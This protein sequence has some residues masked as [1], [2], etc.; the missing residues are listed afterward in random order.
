MLCGALRATSRPTSSID[1]LP[2]LLLPLCDGKELSE[3]DLEDQET[4]PEECQFM[5]EEKK[6]EKDPALR[7]MLIEC[8]LLLVTGI[9]GRQCLRSRG[10]YIVVREAHLR[11][12][13]EKVSLISKER[14]S[15]ERSLENNFD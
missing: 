14:H 4:L 6:R 3:V 11:E 13:D 2:Y 5:D 7:L 15:E 12:N 10:A 1:L 8:L 9:Y